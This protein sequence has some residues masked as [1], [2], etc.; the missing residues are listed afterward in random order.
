[1]LPV[2]LGFG[3]FKVDLST[4]LFYGWFGPR[5]IASILYILVAGSQLGDIRGHEEV[6]AVA[7]LTIC[8]SIILHGLSAQPL[9]ILYAKSH[10]ADK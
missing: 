7:S 1:M 3:F 4:R 5:G 6:F 9:A 8:L 10:P 2:V